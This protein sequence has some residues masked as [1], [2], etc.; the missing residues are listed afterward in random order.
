MPLM[1]WLPSAAPSALLPRMKVFAILLTLSALALAEPPKPDRILKLWEN[2][3]PP[4]DFTVPGPETLTPADK[5]GIARLT[6]VSE[7]RLDFF[8]PGKKNGAAV[9]IVPGGGF[10]ILA[11]EHEGS[12]L[13]VWFRDRGFVAAVLQHRCPTNKLAK[14]WEFPAWD[15]Q[16][17]VSALTAAVPRSIAT[18]TA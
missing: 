14:P 11:S 16:R 3:K 1:K 2:A 9:I 8:S 10:G 15:A 5:N 17:A 12:E 7:P 6:N 13:A 4:G 18:G